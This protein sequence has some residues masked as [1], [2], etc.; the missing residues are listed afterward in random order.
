MAYFSGSQSYALLILTSWALLVFLYD[1]FT[2]KIPNYLSLGAI[3][4]GVLVLIVTGKTIT[5]VDAWSAVMAV[6]VSLLLTMP[7]YLTKKLGGGD[8]KLLLAVGILCGLDVMF[9]SFALASVGVVV[10]YVLIP[11][12]INFFNLGYVRIYAANEELIP[13]GSAIMVGMVSTIGYQF[14]TMNAI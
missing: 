6:L 13:F 8:V 3:C 12:A 9:F 4:I 2:R 11:K 7:G 5:A 1:A 14:W 10:V